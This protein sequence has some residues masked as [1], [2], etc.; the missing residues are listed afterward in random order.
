MKD[1]KK[2]RIYLMHPTPKYNSSFSG[3][4]DTICCINI[5]QLLQG[6]MAWVKSVSAFVY[7]EFVLVS[8]Q[9][10]S[11]AQKNHFW[12]EKKTVSAEN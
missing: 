9:C 1:D 7:Q 5:L 8:V 11:L 4:N 6:K 10:L 12:E 3:I 2:L